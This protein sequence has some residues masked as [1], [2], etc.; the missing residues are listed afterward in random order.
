MYKI[1]TKKKKIPF[2][3]VINVLCYQKK[4]LIKLAKLTETNK[5]NSQL[6]NETVPKG[7]LVYGPGCQIPDFDPLAKNV[8]HLFHIEN[9]EKC[10]DRQ[11]MTN[12]IK[13]YT[14]GDVWLEYDDDVRKK[15][16]PFAQS[17]CYKE[18]T[19]SGTKKHADDQFKYFNFL[20]K[21]I[22]HFI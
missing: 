15:Y 6:L 9:Y 21:N 22:L 1:I 18:I 13:N 10:Y 8:M 2:T 3:C 17:C 7:Y 11:P 14:T 20:I 12:I 19:R 5:T 4:F 16:Y